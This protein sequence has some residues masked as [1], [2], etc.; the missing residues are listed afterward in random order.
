MSNVQNH[1]LGPFTTDLKIII[2]S[3]FSLLS[4]PSCHITFLDRDEGWKCILRQCKQNF[5]SSDSM[6]LQHNT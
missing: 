4:G 2:W 1:V 3:S 5:P 6:S